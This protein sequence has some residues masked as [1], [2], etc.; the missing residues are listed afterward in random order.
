ML[1]DII[2]TKLDEL[3]I[4]ILFLLLYGVRNM[5]HQFGIVIRIPLDIQHQI[6]IILEQQLSEIAVKTMH[7]V[8]QITLEVKYETSTGFHLLH[9]LLHNIQ[10]VDKRLVTV[11][12]M[13]IAVNSVLPD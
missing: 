7:L 2:H 6:R 12:L 4:Q 3:P 10:Q 1:V 13:V 11:L 8:N 5:L 9:F